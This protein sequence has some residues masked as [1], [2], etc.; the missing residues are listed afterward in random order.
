MMLFRRIAIIGS[1]PFPRIANGYFDHL[2]SNVFINDML[3]YQGRICKHFA[4]FFPI[5]GKI[6][7]N[8]SIRW[9]P[10][11]SAEKIKN[12]SR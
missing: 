5:H 2:Q 9:R 7:F 12:C 4:D 11:Y 8:L 1:F 10:G 6:F 3:L